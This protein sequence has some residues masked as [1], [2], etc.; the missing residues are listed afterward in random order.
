[1]TWE[2]IT[3]EEL[4]LEIS[5]GEKEMSAEHLK[6]WNE[7]KFKPTKWIEQEFE[8]EGFWAVAKYKNLVIYYNDVEEGFNI[9]EFEKEGC[10]K[11]YGSEQDELHHALIKLRK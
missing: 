8:D 2:P 11:E 6:F 3:S 10:I 9:S 1:M 4:F 7:I 5:K